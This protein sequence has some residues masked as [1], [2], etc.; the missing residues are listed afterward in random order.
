M[1]VNLDL[2]ARIVQIMSARLNLPVLEERIGWLGV[3]IALGYR[4]N[5]RGTI[6]PI[7]ILIGH[8]ASASH[9]RAQT[10]IVDRSQRYND[11]IERLYL[12]RVELG[13]IARYL[14]GVSHEREEASQSRDELHNLS[15]QLAARRELRMPNGLVYVKDAISGDRI[16]RGSLCES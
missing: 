3:G 1:P 15:A 13:A 2:R 12:I 6:I 11:S 5:W 14:P 9:I 8:E 7:A 10:D 4:V 16:S